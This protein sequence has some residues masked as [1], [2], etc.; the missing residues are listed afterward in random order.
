[1]DP[2][3]LIRMLVIG[4]L[5]GMTSERRLCQEVKLNLAFRGGEPRFLNHFEG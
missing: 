3:V 4:Y 2:E 5:Y 1:V